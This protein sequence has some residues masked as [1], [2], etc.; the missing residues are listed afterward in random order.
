M[1]KKFSEDNIR[2]AA[3]FI[4]EKAG[5]PDTDGYSF[6]MQAIEQL[7][8][9]N[10]CCCGSTKKSSTSKK[11]SM[12]TTSAMK[13]SSVKKATSVKKLSFKK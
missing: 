1:N 2:E 11:T 7:S 12:S 3:Y 9:S 10:G 8:C 6:W 13:T 5:R 4:W